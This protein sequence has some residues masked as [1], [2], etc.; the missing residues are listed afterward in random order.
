M[1]RLPAL[2]RRGEGWL[3]GQVVLFGIAFAAG[4]AGSGAW[5]YELRSVTTVIGGILVI[6]GG[7]L[8]LRGILDLR[9][10]LT[11]LPPPVT[12][13][14]LVASG[15]YGIVRHPIYVGVILG[16]FGWGFFA[17]S[18]AALIVAAVI[19]LFFD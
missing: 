18:P 8:G 13:G 5:R 14:R 11:A 2:G 10:N 17:A 3:A 6:A 7:F 1:S 16:A 19:A 12:G 4:V 15:V 9:A